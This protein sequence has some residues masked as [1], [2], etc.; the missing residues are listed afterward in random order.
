MATNYP[1]SIDSFTRPALDD[2]MNEAGLEG[3][4]VI[5]NL[6]D[7]V[8]AIENELGTNPS[9]SYAT[10]AARIAALS[11][12][13]GLW[14]NVQ[15]YGAVGNGT[16]DDTSEIQAAIAAAGVGG[17]VYFPKATS[18]YKVS[19]SLKPL[20]RQMW[21]GQH[22]P[23]YNWDEFPSGVSTIRA[24][25]SFT[26]TALIHNTATAVAG[27]TIRNLCL[28]GNGEAGTLNGIDFGPASGSERAWRVE[29]CTLNGFGGA[30][31]CGHAWVSTIR[32]CHISRNGYGIRP[33]S[34]ADTGS[35]WLDCMIV[36]NYIYFN[37]HHALAFN[38]S[39][40]C[41][42]ITVMG[43]RLER[44][45]VGVVGNSYDPT[46]ASRDAAACGIYIT[47]ATSINIIG[48]TTDANTGGGLKIDA[49]SFGL[50]NN[51]TSVS[52]IFKRDGIGTNS[53]SDTIA[54]VYINGAQYC[55]FVGDVITYGLPTDGTPPMDVS[56]AIPKRGV[57][58]GATQSQ[59]IHYQGSVQLYTGTTTEGLV[60]T[61]NPDTSSIS[62]P[63]QGY[64]IPSQ[65]AA[66]TDPRPGT[67][68]F[69]SDTNA[70]MFW[71]GS[72]WRTVTST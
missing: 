71:N 50:A 16:A 48:N 2:L 30:A 41:G 69:D 12:L 66:P 32:D 1:N 27:V 46:T 17:V 21:I 14:T 37:Y 4:V 51:I 72:A 60:L 13:S 23:R 36:N 20:E 63:R 25:S 67:W 56:Y 18:Y 70:M 6:Y 52:N 40:S 62:I 68:Y 15:D 10:V 28:V 57:E 11:G 22:S 49:V 44:S 39:G 26:G 34:G 58:F 64:G 54:A 29:S 65:S 47:R 42:M 19:S 35:Q 24:A 59:Y 33:A 9:G 38:G 45:G 53:G 8:E 5:D 7:S 61:T 55:S 31:I 43:N 3:D